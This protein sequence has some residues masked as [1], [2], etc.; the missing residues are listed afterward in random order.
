M[1]SRVECRRKPRKCPVCNS[2]RV[3]TILYGM[4]AYSEK[5]EQDLATGRIALG[6]CC[7]GEDYAAWKCL[8]CDTPIHRGR[9]DG[10]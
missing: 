10:L 1:K 4:P 3:A 8:E 5:L 7:V 2:S 6:G 9:V